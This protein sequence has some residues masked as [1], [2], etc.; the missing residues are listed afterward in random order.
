MYIKF[1]YF[2]QKYKISI[3]TS[4]DRSI[5]ENVVQTSASITDDSNEKPVKT[6]SD[7]MEDSVDTSTKK[8]SY[9]SMTRQVSSSTENNKGS[10]N[11]P[12]TDVS[13]KYIEVQKV[14]STVNTKKENQ[15]L[16]W[17]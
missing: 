3:G 16:R 6:K 12:S 4:N 11:R 1:E 7:S 9:E 13:H 5:I 2:E 8:G 10:I 15:I 17:I 14:S